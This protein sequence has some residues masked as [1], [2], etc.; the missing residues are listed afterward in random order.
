M[1]GLGNLYLQLLR[2]ALRKGKV[3][4][5]L[6]GHKEV[7][8]RRGARRTERGGLPAWRPEHG[9]ER[10][11]AAPR[12]EC[13]GPQP[14]LPT[15]PPNPT[16]P[17]SQLTVT[18]ALPF[19][20]SRYAGFLRLA[21]FKAAPKSVPLMYPIVESFRLSMLAMS[22]PDFPFNVL[23]AVLARNTTE[24]ARPIAVDEKLAYTWV[25]RG[26]VWGSC[27]RDGAQR[28]GARA[29]RQRATLAG[30]RRRGLRS[31]RASLTP[32]PPPC[33]PAAAAS[34]PTTC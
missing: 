5:S 26:G 10:R 23:G 8:V 7:K 24:V 20:P 19:D 32:P 18:R 21:G 27:V 2:A 33:G 14:P 9:E 12:F 31:R 30:R 15:P 29:P 6:K 16:P 11:S 22:H 4:K 34:T 3:P 28:R 25:A 13:A 1:P 17:A